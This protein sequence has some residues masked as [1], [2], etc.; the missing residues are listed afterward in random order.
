M[1]FNKFNL[2]FY[3]AHCHFEIFSFVFRT[4]FVCIV[5]RIVMFYESFEFYFLYC[6]VLQIYTASG[7]AKIPAVL[8]YLGTMVEV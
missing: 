5:V 2:V 6:V 3:R 1:K 8:D 4:G 7:E